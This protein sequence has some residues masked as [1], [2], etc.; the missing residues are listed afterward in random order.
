MA[1]EHLDVE[2]Y[3]LAHSWS[4]F[5]RVHS[6]NGFQTALLITTV[7]AGMGAGLTPA[8]SQSAGTAIAGSTG[9]PASTPD[10]GTTAEVITVTARRKAEKLQNVPLSITAISAQTLKAADA[11]S[12]QDITFLTPGLTYTSNGQE[13]DATPTIRGISDTSGGE[14]TSQNV[15]IFLDGV[16]IKN[17]SA[18]D[19]AINGLDRVEIVKGPVSGLYGRN[20]FTGAINY[21]TAN[22]S[23]DL[24]ADEEFTV[25]NDGRYITDT[26]VSGPIVPD[27]LSGLISFEYNHLD[28]TYTDPVSKVEGNGHDR[29]DILASL[30]FTPNEHITIKPVFYYGY[31]EFNAPVDVIYNQNCAIGTANSVCGNLNKNQIGPNIP[32]S[33]GADTTGLTRRVQNFHVDTKVSYDFGTFDVLA[34]WNKNETESNNDFTGLDNGLPYELYVAGHN[35]AFGPSEPLNKVAYLKSFFGDHATEQDSSVEARYDSPQDFPIRVGV[36]GYWLY[37]HSENNNVFGIDS[38]NIPA[39]DQINS[40]AQGYVDAVGGPGAALNAASQATRDYSGFV[41]GEWDI[42]PTLTLSTAVRQTEELQRQTSAYDGIQSKD[43]HA[44]TSNEALTWKPTP[45]YTLYVS[46]ANG[47]K[48]GGFNGE[49]EGVSDASF[50]PETDW[51]YEGGIKAT[52]LQNHL[53]LDLAVFHLDINNLQV[54]GP[55]STAGALGDV[56]KNYGSLGETGFELSGNYVVGNGLKLLAGFEFGQPRFQSGSYDVTDAGAC[57]LI[58]SCAGSRLTTFKGQ[59]AVN[60]KGLAPPYS[61]DY[62]FNVTAE[63]TRPTGFFE[64]VDWFARGDYRFEAKQYNTVTDFAYYGPR[65][66]LNLHAGLQGGSWTFSGNVLNATN[67]LTPT[68]MQFDGSLNTLAIGPGGNGGVFWQPTSVLPEGRTFFFKIGYHFGGAHPAMPE[69]PPPPPPVSSVPQQAPARTY[70]VFFD[71]DRSDLTAR[72]Q[73]IVATAAQASTQVQTTR[74]EVDGYTDLSGTAAY[75]QKLSIK[76]AKTVEAALVHDG[77]P[78]SEISIHGYGESNPLVPTAAGVREPQNRRVE[79]ILK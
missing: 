48:S 20:A 35:A 29:K 24:R 23:Q 49:S 56:V 18:I 39:G 43:F 45:N 58:A 63:Y 76:R 21:I 40:I 12:L 10:S 3:A 69:P 34:G 42:I 74:I 70:L 77:V 28:G 36:G 7:L 71:W 64:N 61:S 9:K 11:T 30:L 62:T 38:T 31:D 50:N 2:H 55:P 53:L 79:I 68:T 44:V 4:R 65:N 15:S 37:D 59:S 47:S 60:L 78:T 26:L 32:T 72:A 1:R 41:S 6:G 46:A 8:R 73:Q 14:A 27:I 66:V 5:G 51:D 52:M 19:L 33:T 22:A 67:D 25:G 57:A 54:I 16:Y 75:N 13:A 17:P